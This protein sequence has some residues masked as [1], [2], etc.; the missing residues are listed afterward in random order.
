MAAYDHL[1][2]YYYSRPNFQDGT[3]L[4]H[5]LVAQFVPP[6]KRVLEIGA[7]PSNGTTAF[8]ASRSTVVGLDVSPEIRENRYLEEARVFDGVTF[9]FAD[10]SFDACCSNYVLEHVPNPQDHFAEVFRI[11]KPGGVYCFRTPNRWHYVALA[12]S[13][14]PHPAHVK[15]ANRL[16]DLD[17]HAHAPYPTAYRANTRG[18]LQTLC[19]QA[20]LCA[21]H[22]VMVEK[23]PSYARRYQLLFW[24]MMFYE[25]LVNSTE[26]MAPFRANI[27]GCLQKPL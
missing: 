7:G 1:N 11:L 16:R 2:K 14:L 5:A 27:F 25:K 26:F 19:R 24:P 17:A 22:F 13:L 21:I 3:A 4:F 8:L 9:P 6:G 23:E 15:L 20:G 12:S 18:R 10:R